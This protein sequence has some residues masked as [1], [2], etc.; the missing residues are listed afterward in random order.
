M[1]SLLDSKPMCQPLPSEVSVL[2][3]QPW[4]AGTGVTCLLLHFP[5][6]QTSVI[7]SECGDI[8]EREALNATRVTRL[9]LCR[10][11]KKTKI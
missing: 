4:V 10:V 9:E 2:C 11:G 6:V 5:G 8:L 7:L 1:L 3:D